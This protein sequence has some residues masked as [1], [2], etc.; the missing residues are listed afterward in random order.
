VAILFGN[1]FNA[2]HDGVGLE[3]EANQIKRFAI[4]NLPGVT[5]IGLPSKTWGVASDHVRA[6]DDALHGVS[7]NDDGFQCNCHMCAFAHRKLNPQS[8]YPDYQTLHRR[9]WHRLVS[10]DLNDIIEK[11]QRST[12]QV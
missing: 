12:P 7:F 3:E 11:R 6:G 1:R 9:A 10:L 5:A 8:P 4:A 2:D